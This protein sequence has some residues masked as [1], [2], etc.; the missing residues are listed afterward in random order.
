[1]KLKTAMAHF[2]DG[3]GELFSVECIEHAGHTWLVTRWNEA[4]AEGWKTPARLVMLDNLPHQKTGRAFGDYNVQV[5]LPRSLFYDPAPWSG[6]LPFVVVD[7]PP[8]MRV[9]IPRG[10]H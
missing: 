4:P 8:E 9:P 5:G 7:Q 6:E 1:M 2:S 3:A 10:I